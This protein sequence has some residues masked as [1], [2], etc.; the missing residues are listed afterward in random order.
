[1]IKHEGTGKF[2]VRVE[3]RNDPSDVTIY[4]STHRLGQNTNYDAFRTSNKYKVSKENK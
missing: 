2:G 3:L 4:W 1:M